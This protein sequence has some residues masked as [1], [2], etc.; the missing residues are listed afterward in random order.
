LLRWQ[1]CLCGHNAHTG[2]TFEELSRAVFFFF[3]FF[4]SCDQNTLPPVLK[5]FRNSSESPAKF[6]FPN[7][8][9]PMK[10]VGL[11]CVG[12]WFLVIDVS[13][14]PWCFAVRSDQIIVDQVS[15]KFSTGL[16]VLLNYLVICCESLY[17]VLQA[18]PA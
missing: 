10:L 17:C 15:D 14:Q 13:D 1:Y 9:F 5:L 2:S 11:S 4:F 16:E 7:I 18:V 12:C 8:C 3:F 6:F